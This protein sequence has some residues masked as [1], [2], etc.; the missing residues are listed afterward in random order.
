MSVT[1]RYLNRFLFATRDNHGLVLEP[2]KTSDIGVMCLDHVD[3]NGFLCTPDRHSTI[4]ISNHDLSSCGGPSDFPNFVL[5][6]Q[7]GCLLGELLP[8]HLADVVDSDFSLI[9]P[10]R[11]EVVLDW[12]EHQSSDG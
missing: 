4:F 3:G 10:C 12:V 11:E 2:R 9:V 7:A 1:C 6:F 8:S 5:A